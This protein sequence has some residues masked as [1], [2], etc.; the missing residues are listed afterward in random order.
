MHLVAVLAF[1]G[2][3]AFD[4]TTAT[5]VFG[6]VRLA[7]GAAGTRSWSPGRGAGRRRGCSA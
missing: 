6:G 1:D 7:D 2:V 5:E 3:V 4:V